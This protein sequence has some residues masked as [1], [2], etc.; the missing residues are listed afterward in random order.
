MIYLLGTCGDT[1]TVNVSFH[2]LVF[3]TLQGSRSHPSRME[4]SLR[5]FL[6]GWQWIFYKRKIPATA[7]PVHDALRF[8]HNAPLLVYSSLAMLVINIKLLLVF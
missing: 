1:D 8:R 2:R 6:V 4:P 3:Y 7:H 5:R